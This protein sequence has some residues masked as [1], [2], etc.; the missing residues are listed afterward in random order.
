MSAGAE[1]KFFFQIEGA[2][3]ESPRKILTAKEILELAKEKNLPAAKPPLEEL[4]L[5]GKNKVYAGNDKV[6]LSED[7]DFSL[8]LRLYKFKVNGRELE[9]KFEKL[10]A[11]DIIEMAGKQGASIPGG[12]PDKLLLEAVG[13]EKPCQFKLDEWVDLSRFHEF[14]LILNEPTPVA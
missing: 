6:D 2:G 3:F 5:K 8:G 12:E 4:A 9:S 7:N 14:L 13:G 10:I 11:L 1:N